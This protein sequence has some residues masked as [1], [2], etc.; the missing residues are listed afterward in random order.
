MVN[1]AMLMRGRLR[2]SKQTLG[3]LYA[4]TPEKD[5][6]CTVVSDSEDDFRV[7]RLLRSYLDH[8]NFALLE[9]NNSGHVLA[10][11]KNLA[12]GWSSQRFGR[13]DWLYI[14]DGDVYFCPGWLEK[15]TTVAICS[16]ANNFRLWGGQIHPFH[17]PINQSSEHPILCQNGEL[18]IPV[19]MTEHSILDGPS[20]LMRWKT[21]NEYGPFSRRNE[22]G[23]CRSE[24]YPFCQRLTAPING[25]SYRD[26]EA[27]NG[28]AWGGGRIGV[29]QPHVV[30]HTGL[31]QTDGRDA[32]G[33]KEREAMIPEGV[34]AE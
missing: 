23:P 28:Q 16:E 11:L 24:E 17:H 18:A 10:Q 31:T 20:W 13:A 2:L 12:V 30:I 27:H 19:H 22:P 3:S 4:N 25:G 29:I 8:K 21:W 33:R 32:P 7:T 15:L 5:F 14:S 6:T 9:A 1:I 34:L 26:A